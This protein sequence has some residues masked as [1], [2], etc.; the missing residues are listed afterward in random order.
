MTIPNVERGRM[1]TADQQNDLIDQVNENTSDIALLILSG[2]VGPDPEEIQG[3][4]DTSV[5]SHVDDLTPHPVYDDLPSLT[6]LF[7]NGLI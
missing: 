7:E 3:M 1:I 6:I 4:I 5:T 2:G